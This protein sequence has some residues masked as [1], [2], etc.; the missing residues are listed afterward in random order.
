MAEA[1]SFISKKTNKSVKLDHLKRLENVLLCMIIEYGRT[2]PR[3]IINT[4]LDHVFD[5]HSPAVFEPLI[6]TDGKILNHLFSFPETRHVLTVNQFIDLIGFCNVV[7]KG[8]DENG[9][10][11]SSG[12]LYEYSKLMQSNTFLSE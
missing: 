1:A 4:L 9:R 5:I 6:L 8:D 3:K 7:I 10:G 11:V 2:V 12:I